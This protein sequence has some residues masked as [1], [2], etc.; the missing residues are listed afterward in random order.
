M[1]AIRIL[2]IVISMQL[3]AIPTGVLHVCAMLDT[4]AMERFVKVWKQ[5]FFDHILTRIFKL[6]KS[7]FS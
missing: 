3:A 1:N 4:P 2:M 5:S 7:N 6:P